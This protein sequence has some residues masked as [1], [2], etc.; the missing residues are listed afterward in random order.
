MRKVLLTGAAGLIGTSLRNILG[1]Q[2]D[3]RCLDIKP[4][5][6]EE[7]IVIADI[8]D[9]DAL[10]KAMEGVDAVIHMAANPGF[11]SQWEDV[12]NNGIGGTYNVFEAARIAGV[13]KIIYASS[14]VVL[15][16]R[17]MQQGKKVSPDMPVR[18]VYLYGV[19]KAIGEQLASYFVDSYQIS[20]ICLRIGIFQA[21]PPA[22]LSSDDVILQ[23]WCSPED[24]AQLV[25]RCLQAEDLG[26]QV[27]YA[28]SDNKKRLWDIDNARKLV[29]FKPKSNAE[30]YI[31]PPTDFRKR[32]GVDKSHI[33]LMRAAVQN[34]L[35]ALEN[36]QQW[37]KLVDIERE[38]LDTISYRLLP[39][40]YQN[41]AG[42]NIDHPLMARLKGVYRRS[43]LENQLSME[44]VVSFLAKLHD[45][46]IPIM[47]LDDMTSILNLYNGQGVRKLYSLDILVQPDD[48]AR[49]LGLLEQSEIWPKVSYGNHF[50]NV[51]TPL[52][53]WSPF[54]LP[55]S[56][57][58]R[59]LP[60]IRSH[61]QAIA[62]WQRGNS[63]F[64]GDYPVFTLDMESHFLRSCIRAIGTEPEAAYFA[65]IDVAWML[66]KPAVN[67]N[68]ERVV[69]LAREYHLVLPVLDTLEEITSFMT[70]TK[71]DELIFKLQK[72]PFTW[73]D[74][75]E[76]EFIYPYQPYPKPFF[77]V[78]RRLLLYR[79]SLK[80]PGV[81]GFLRYLQY[82]WGGGRLLSLPR[83]AIRHFITALK[84]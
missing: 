57:G 21:D 15:G 31:K 45:Q 27:F 34:D 67:T 26:F 46:N 25:L 78:I 5:E 51:E 3:F 54:E 73:M 60:M 33:L 9:F 68:W 70:I 56:V 22:P 69:E 30:D 14:T 82:V 52:E 12:Y 62:T 17:E 40:V 36:W 81:L 58:W 76:N 37:L 77:K 83:L 74:R 11:E 19:G 66:E 24:L 65:L 44:K 32:G 10:I 20:I 41:L 1:R 13:K 28:V 35:D 6:D 55:C 63:A 18:P 71:A 38:N 49:L 23:G 48:V 7:D 39:L 80:L 75:M 16:W 8:M 50:L 59:V 79:R 42:L 53:I 29:G 43:W 84:H 72:F 4:M 61:E 2:I 47:L 64:V